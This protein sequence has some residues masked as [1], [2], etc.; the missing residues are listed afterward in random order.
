MLATLTEL[1]IL[2]GL[3]KGR[4]LAQIAEEC[5]LTQPAISKI[6]HAFE[7]RIGIQ[8]TEQAGRRLVLTPIGQDIAWAAQRAESGLQLFEEFL[9]DVRRGT[10]GCLRLIASY[11]PGNHVLPTIIGDFLRAVPGSEVI[12]QVEPADRLC[13]VFMSQGHDL[14]I[15]PWLGKTVGLSAEWL[16]S[17]H[18]TFF[19]A[20]QSD[21]AQR[22][23]V[24][25]DEVCAQPIIAPFA[26][27]YWIRFFDKL[28]QRGFV[29]RR[30][31]NIGAVD[32]IR[33]L[34]ARG[35]G[36]GV[37]FESALREEFSTGR[38]VQLE[39]EGLWEAEPIFLFQRE[40][41][42][43][44]PLARRFRTFL[45]SEITKQFRPSSRTGAQLSPCHPHYVSTNPA[46]G[47]S[48]VPGA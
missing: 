45:M 9:A 16:Y 46:P 1:D 40:H 11:T 15:G 20:P 36:V 3:A 7:R 42:L 24:T 13:E 47:C 6:L 35:A 38:F 33:Y 37:R 2:S 17:H 23:S 43:P 8:L 41:L 34:V 30:R 39:I 4:T 27:P 26:Q 32:G 18:I 10:A 48:H 22:A 28:A 14:A 31:I 19:V 12:L 21:L 25:W 5:S 44:T 29:V